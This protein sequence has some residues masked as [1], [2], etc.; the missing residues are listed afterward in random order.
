[1][2]NVTEEQ[3]I[4]VI[5]EERNVNAHNRLRAALKRKKGMTLRQIEAIL[6]KSFGMIGKWLHYMGLAGR[7]H[8][9]H[10]GAACKLKPEQLVELRKNMVAGPVECGFESGM[11][12]APMV[13]AHVH[14]KFDIEYKRGG[15]EGLLRR[16]GFSWRK[17][18]PR[19]PKAA[20]EE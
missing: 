12:T 11:W 19:H 9:A 17:A 10:P 1:M 7:Y 5:K 3:L 15:M 14:R 4:S 18:R 20:S 2:P 13:I 8:D 16:M 6:D